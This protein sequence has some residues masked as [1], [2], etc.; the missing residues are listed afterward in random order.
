MSIEW[1]ALELCSR[2]RGLLPL[3]AAAA[4]HR[5]GTQCSIHHAST[6]HPTH[7]PTSSSHCCSASL[8]FTSHRLVDTEPL[9]GT[10]W[11]GAGVGG[12]AAHAE[13]SVAGVALCGGG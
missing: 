3:Q 1:R 2:R 10:S 9:E 12:G 6:M 13:G 5:H 11:G 7:P 8:S 4:G